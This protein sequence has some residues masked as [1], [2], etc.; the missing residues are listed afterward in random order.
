M[1]YY[2]TGDQVKERFIPNC[3]LVTEKYL[4]LLSRVNVLCSFFQVLFHQLHITLYMLIVLRASDLVQKPTS[5]PDRWHS[6][7]GNV[8]SNQ[9]LVLPETS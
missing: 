2:Q 6:L 4:D 3:G 7:E 8:A 5:Q 1:K 9:Y